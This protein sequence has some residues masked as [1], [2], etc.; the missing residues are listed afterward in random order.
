MEEKEKIDTFL[1]AFKELENYLEK[2]DGVKDE[3][4]P[5]S[6]M[7]SDIYYGRKDPLISQYDTYDFLKNAAELRNT[8]S[9]E[10]DICVPSSSFLERFLSLKEKIIHPLNVYAISTKEIHSAILET[11]LEEVIGIMKEFSLSHVPLLD[12]KDHLVG[13]FSRTTLFDYIQNEGN[14]LSISSLKMKDFI[15]YIDINNHSN[16]R[17]VFVSRWERVDTVFPYLLKSKEHEKNIG[18]LLVTENGKE[19]EKILGLITLTDIAKYKI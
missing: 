2:L 12:E 19:N 17:F 14:M 11:S 9:H 16:E 15:P 5:F 1:S 3:Y 18:L 6:R 7:L 13:V 10:N 8:L 4:V